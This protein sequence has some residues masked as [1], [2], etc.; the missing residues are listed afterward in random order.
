MI[1]CKTDFISTGMAPP[2]GHVFTK[3][4]LDHGGD[5]NM[6]SASDGMTP[7][8]MAVGLAR[9]DT[10]GLLLGAGGR[11]ESAFDLLEPQKMLK[12]SWRQ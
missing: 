11:E 7:V 2:F 12:A 9:E 8:H 3:L 5:P 6:S 1:D 10:L 4:C